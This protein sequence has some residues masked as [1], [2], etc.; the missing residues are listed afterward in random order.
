MSERVVAI[1]SGGDWADASCEHLILPLH[2][3]L[4][5]EYRNYS[6]WY[7]EEY[8]SSYPKKVAYMTF[9]EWLKKRG[10]T[11]APIEEFGEP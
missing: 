3:D 8:R 10:A 9:T 4:A 1:R 2:L 6:R 11:D 7:E 5:D